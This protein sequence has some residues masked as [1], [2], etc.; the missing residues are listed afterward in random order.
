MLTI[1]Y[2]LLDMNTIYLILLNVNYR[3]VYRLPNA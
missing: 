3:Y 2:T 1:K